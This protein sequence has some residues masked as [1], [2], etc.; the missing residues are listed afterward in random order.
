MSN[1]IDTSVDGMEPARVQ[2]RANGSP[3]SAGVN[4]L[5]APDHAVLS[6]RQPG[7]LGVQWLI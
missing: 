6:M 4:E 1:G 3:S 7:D 5:P 2:P